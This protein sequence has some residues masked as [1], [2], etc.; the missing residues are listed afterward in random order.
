MYRSETFIS[1]DLTIKYA[2]EDNMLTFSAPTN[3]R[4]RYGAPVVRQRPTRL[5]RAAARAAAAAKRNAAKRPAAKGRVAAA[6]A[7]APVVAVPD[8]AAPLDLA[9]LEA[10]Q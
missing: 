7:A 8:A 9:F 10:S 3:T 6:A 1:G 2:R 5:A 4:N